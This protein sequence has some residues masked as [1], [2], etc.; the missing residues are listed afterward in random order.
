MANTF[1]TVDRIAQRALPILSDSIVFP[2]LATLDYSA[3]FAQEGDTIQV[4][5]PSVFIADEFS[6]TINLQDINP[7][8]VL[9]KMDKIADVS[10]TVTSKEMTLDLDDFET[11]VLRP[12]M[13]AISEKI[14]ADGLDLYKFVGAYVGASG[15]TPDGLDDFA[16]AAKE[17][18]DNKAPFTER[19]G[20]WDTASTAKF[21]QLDSLVE[22]DKSG[23]NT[24]L[25]T[26][27]I[28]NVYGIDNYMSQAVKTHTAGGYTAL[29]DITAAADIS[30]VNATDATTGLK[31][32]S[33]TLTSAAGTSTATLLAGDI[34]TFADDSGNVYKAT[35]LEDTAAAVS[36]VVTA[37]VLPQITADDVTDT[38]VTFP[39]VTARAHK[40]N[41]VFNRNAFGFVTR[42]LMPA[43]GADS[44]TQSFGGLSIRVVMDYD[45]STKKTV[46]SMDI[47]YGWAALYPELATRVLG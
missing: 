26:G 10:V 2:Q 34:L 23:T 47:L 32:T 35:V 4:K 13:V 7:F 1:L 18:D 30:A 44:S 39:D 21:R 28:G 36:G 12:A 20:I 29:A 14:N 6:G 40:A 25:R 11:D 16:N 42:P 22:V 41:L 8:P 9:V 17:L 15:T 24:A 3:T 38:D 31:Y 27:A 43:P 5:R 33:V 19:F 45:T 46:M 37:K